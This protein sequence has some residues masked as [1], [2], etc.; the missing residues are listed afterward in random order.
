MSTENDFLPFA[1]GGSANVV[2]QAAYAALASTLLQTGFTAGV[3]PSVQLNKVWRQ[4]SIMA[5]VIA[6]FIVAETGQTAIDDGTTATLL[7]NFTAA[8]V[9][10]SKQQVIL[11]DT[12]AVNAYAAANPVPLTALPTASGVSQ[13]FQVAHSNTGASTYAPDGLAAHPIFGL[14]GVA[15][16]GGEMPVGGVA[17]LVSY[18]G[19]LLNSGALCWVLYDCTGGAEQIAPA[20]Q[21]AHAVQLQQIGHGQCRFIFSSATATKLIPYNGQNLIINGAPQ[22][23]PSAGV[24]LANTSLAASTFYYVYAAM[25]S[26]V[27]TLVASATGHVTG[28]NGVEVMIGDATKTLVGSV[29]TNSSSQFSTSNN[30]YGVISWFNRQSISL[31]PVTAVNASFSSATPD[32]INTGNRIT[33]ISWLGE[34]VLCT[35]CGYISN[36]ASQAACVVGIGFNSTSVITGQLAQG[37]VPFAGAAISASTTITPFIGTENQAQY[38]TPLGEVSAGSGSFNIVNTVTI[39]G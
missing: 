37:N 24:S 13:K 25:V 39:R 11:T 21:P 9:A 23:I 10:A 35:V 29:L 18:V 38:M 5:A 17:G 27:M 4:S 2:T 12:G 20:T 8:I 36:T 32:E 22:Q 19:P 33:F 28:S 14:G 34:S 26:G 16:Q 30:F 6:Q 3:A 1:V 31:Q 15:L 7:A